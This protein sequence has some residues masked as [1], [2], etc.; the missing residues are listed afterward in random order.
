[1]SL[2]GASRRA[3]RLIPSTVRR[4]SGAIV[5]DSVQRAT[6]REQVLVARRGLAV[7]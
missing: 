6:R 2:A 1:M 4:E 5:R 3:R 7:Y